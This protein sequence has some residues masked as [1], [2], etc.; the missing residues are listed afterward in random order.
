MERK[1]V[2]ETAICPSLSI[3]SLSHTTESIAC[4]MTSQLHHISQHPLQL[5]FSVKCKQMWCLP[6][7]VQHPKTR[8]CPLHLLF[9]IPAGYNPVLIKKMSIIHWKGRKTRWK[10]PGLLNC[11]V[12]F[13]TD[14]CSSYFM[15]GSSPSWQFNLL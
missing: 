1:G 3:L 13:F 8:L 11:G 15:F 10:E 5:V 14:F 12:E 9:L 6:L 7:A 2:T 4:H